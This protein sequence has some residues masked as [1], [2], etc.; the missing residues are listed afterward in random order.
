[1]KKSPS[2]PT[3]L[4]AGVG[5]AVKTLRHV[6]GTSQQDLAKRTGF[7]PNAIG[8]IEEGGYELTVGDIEKLADAFSV[9][10][11]ELVAFGETY[12][13]MREFPPDNGE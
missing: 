7:D 10:E 11:H 8:A 4:S 9:E 3:S 2:N 5:K 12:L 1:M 6:G 13:R